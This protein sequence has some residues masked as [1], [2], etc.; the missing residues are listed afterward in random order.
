MFEARRAVEEGGRE[1]DFVVNIGRYPPL[2][3]VS[4]GVG[5]W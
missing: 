2:S 1:V 4:W 5:I 3:F